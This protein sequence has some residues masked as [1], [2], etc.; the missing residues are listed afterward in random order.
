[1]IGRGSGDFNDLAA[2]ALDQRAVL[3]FGVNDDNVVI[4]SAA[5]KFYMV[6][7]SSLLLPPAGGILGSGFA[8]QVPL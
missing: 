7:R 6:F 3:G 8:L 5:D 4:R 1:M 2:Q